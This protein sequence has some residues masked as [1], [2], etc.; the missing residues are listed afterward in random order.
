LARISIIKIKL[1]EY[2]FQFTPFHQLPTD[3]TVEICMLIL[4]L[5]IIIIQYFSFNLI[6]ENKNAKSLIAKAKCCRDA[7]NLQSSR[8]HCN[9]LIKQNETWFMTDIECETDI[10]E[11]SQ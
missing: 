7:Y 2:T 10:M 11:E 5:L 1:D 9:F 6:D 8:I 4:S 3:N